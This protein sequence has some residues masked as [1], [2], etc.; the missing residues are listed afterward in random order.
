MLCN[1][2]GEAYDSLTGEGLCVECYSD[3]K[4]FFSYQKAEVKEKFLDLACR[5]SPENLSCDGELSK[6]EIRRKYKKLMS[7]WRKLEK[8]IGRKVSEHT[9]WDRECAG[10]KR[11]KKEFHT[12][13][14]SVSNVDLKDLKRQRL[15]LFS[16]D[17]DEAH[18][19]TNLLDHMI[20]RAEGY[21]P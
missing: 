12:V 5:L 9:V 11:D 2:C 7:E 21:I 18:G 10:D 20:D 6:S 15:W 4:I 8:R 14:I 19:L 1:N 13:D 16:Q 3:E 17:C